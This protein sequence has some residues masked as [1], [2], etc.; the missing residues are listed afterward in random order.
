MDFGVQNV[1]SRELCAVPLNL[2]YLNGDID[3][4]LK[5]IS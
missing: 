3:I 1:L 2:F 5:V 4:L